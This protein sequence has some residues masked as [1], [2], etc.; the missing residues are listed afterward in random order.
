MDDMSSSAAAA[1]SALIDEQTPDQFTTREDASGS[2]FRETALR[3][4]REFA[5]GALTLSL[6]ALPLLLAGWSLRTSPKRLFSSLLVLALI[7]VFYHL[8]GPV[9]SEGQ[10]RMQAGWPY[11]GSYLAR[12]GL[13][14][15]EIA[16]RIG[17]RPIWTA[18]TYTLPWLVGWWV[19]RASWLPR[20]LLTGAH[21]GSGSDVRT[22]CASIA[23]SM[24]AVQSVVLL[25][26]QS[27]YDRYLPSAFL[28]VLV[29]A[30]GPFLSIPKRSW[31]AGRQ[32]V[33]HGRAFTLV[34]LTILGLGLSLEWTR[35]QIDRGR[36][37][38]SVANTLVEKGNPP[39]SISAGFEWSGHHLFL[40]AIDELGAKPPFDMTSFPWAPFQEPFK[41]VVSEKRDGKLGPG[42]PIAGYRGF[43]ERD[44]RYIGARQ[45]GRAGSR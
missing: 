26:A 34:T 17:S 16:S 41:F 15:P 27:F 25:V 38:W 21:V 3:A 10:A 29:L 19:V 43:L 9:L 39:E 14:A 44:L 23:V 42:G 36:A 12:R 45:T 7:G 13:I 32:G 28:A 8:F 11:Q 5:A 2:A 1:A 35:F 6:L 30:G 18:I 31:R 40:R 20:N 37:V 4:V 33:R 22:R 24:G